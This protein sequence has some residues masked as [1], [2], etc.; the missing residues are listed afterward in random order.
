MRYKD[1]NERALVGQIIDNGTLLVSTYQELLDN[2]IPESN[3]IMIFPGEQ[4]EVT[5]DSV[6]TDL[7]PSIRQ[8]SISA[9]MNLR[10]DRLIT[11]LW[12]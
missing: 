9:N 2:K 7:V 11:I 3:A 6:K 12:R 5:I 8:A 1:F 10:S 4:I